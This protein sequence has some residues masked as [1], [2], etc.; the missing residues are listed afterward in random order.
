MCA[1]A[2]EHLCEPPHV[3]AVVIHI[4]DVGLVHVS[5]VV[6]APPNCLSQ[7]PRAAVGCYGNG[8]SL[9][10]VLYL[11]G[12]WQEGY[13]VHWVNLYVLRSNPSTLCLLAHAWH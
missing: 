7:V 4:Y 5:R 2:M 10:N 9:L 1:E 8:R 3:V 11:P 13:A 6:C 12:I